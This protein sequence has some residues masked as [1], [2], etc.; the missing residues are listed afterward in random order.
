MA[1]LVIGY[2]RVSS[3]GQKLDV[4]RDALLAAGCD[5][6]YEEKVS[7]TSMDRPMLEQLLTSGTRSGDTVVIT[8]IDRLARSLSLIHI[9]EP[10]RPY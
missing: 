1:N 4:Q 7:G 3:V 9:S 5:E 8:K 2:A 6:I 10:T